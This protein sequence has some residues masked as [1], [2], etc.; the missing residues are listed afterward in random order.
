MVRRQFS[1]VAVTG[2]KNQLSLLSQKR[3]SVKKDTGLDDLKL[4]RQV[5][6]AFIPLG[7]P[8]MT[9]PFGNVTERG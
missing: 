3:I 4:R 1:A 6:S 7:E 8:V 2:S 9:L 5:S